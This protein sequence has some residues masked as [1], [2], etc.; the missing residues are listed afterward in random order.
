MKVLYIATAISSLMSGSEMCMG[1]EQ[2]SRISQTN[3]NVLRQIAEIGEKFVNEKI[4]EARSA[5]EAQRNQR[6]GEKPRTTNYAPNVQIIDGRSRPACVH[7]P[8][9]TVRC[10][11]MW[12]TLINT[13][14]QFM[15]KRTMS[16]TFTN[17][18]H[19]GLPRHTE[20]HIASSVHKFSCTAD[21]W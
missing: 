13:W 18:I 9:L 11:Q 15:E 6:H 21:R 8:L 1:E 5:G 17:E 4:A 14:H 2:V 19:S 16:W 7:P 12:G 10:P 3:I 20:V